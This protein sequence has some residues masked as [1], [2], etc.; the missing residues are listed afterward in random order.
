MIQGR[1]YNSVKNFGYGMLTYAI[2]IL[3]SFLV[4]GAFI[5]CLSIEYLGIEALFTGI[6]TILSL[7][8]LGFGVVM[9][10]ALYAPLAQN[11][12]Q[13]IAAYLNLYANAYH[14]IGIIVGTIGLILLPFLDFLINNPPQGLHNIHLIYSL[15]LLDSVLSYFFAYKRAL[16]NADQKA[17]IC[18]Q[19][20]FF[21]QLIKACLQISTLFIFHNYL[22]FLGIQIICTCSENIFLAHIVNHRYSFLK[23]YR[24][25]H[26]N[27][28]EKSEIK[29]NVKALIISNFS[30][31]ALRSS[32]NIIIPTYVGLKTMGY[33]SNYVLI[34][35]ALST[36]I[37]QIFSGLTASLG[38]YLA[39]EDSSKHKELFERLDFLNFWLYGLATVCFFSLANPFIT[40]WLGSDYT[41]SLPIL[42]IISTNF[43]IEGFLTTLWL[44][45]TTMGLF[46][47]GKYRPVFSAVLNISLALILG[48]RFGLGGI[49]MATTFARLLVNSWFDPYIIYTCGLKT[50]PASYFVNTVPKLTLIVT[51]GIL[52]SLTIS[53]STPT[54]WLSFAVISILSFLT[55]NLIFYACFRHSSHLDYF[56][57]LLKSFL[58]KSTTM[59][60]KS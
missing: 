3:I 9:N 31:V 43:L 28:A 7:G 19:V 15:F 55:V 17:Y 59:A 8:E 50:S 24:H 27:S 25:E 58:N 37:S 53:Y 48:Q 42:I 6:L 35:G 20:H 10:Q 22:I 5:S 57:S 41:L 38:N 1:V 34:L 52:L 60:S 29:A 33:Y 14:I 16:L 12:H 46:T 13:K 45:R 21:V 32:T 54:S 36:V 39:S 18:S 11:N 49:L 23:A 44:F 40:I 51:V 47:Q 26:L 2:S 56:R 30:R 4:R